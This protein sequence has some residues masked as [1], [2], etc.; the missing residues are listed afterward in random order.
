MRRKGSGHQRERVPPQH[1]PRPGAEGQAPFAVPGAPRPGDELGRV[2]GQR[3]PGDGD[4]REHRAGLA[5]P[6]HDHDEHPGDR[7]RERVERLG[8]RMRQARKE[9]E[10]QRDRVRQRARP[11]RRADGPPRALAEAGEH[12]AAECVRAEPVG[13]ARSLQ[14]RP[15]GDAAAA[16]EP[17]GDGDQQRRRG[18]GE[19]DQMAPPT[20]RDG[21]GDRD[22]GGVGGRAGEA[23]GPGPRGEPRGE[24]EGDEE[25]QARLEDREVLGVGGGQGGAAEPGDGEDGLDGD[26]RARDADG[27][28]RR[29]RGERR[30]GAAQEGA[31][32][33]GARVPGGAP[34]PHPVL[35]GDLADGVAA[36]AGGDAAAGQA[37]GERGQDQVRGPVE[38]VRG[39]EAEPGGEDGDAEGR[40]EEVGQGGE[41][42]DGDAAGSDGPSRGGAAQGGRARGGGD[43]G[44]D[45][46][47]RAHDGEGG[48]EG[49][50]DGVG[51]GFAAGP[52]GAE[53]A[54]GESGEPV[55]EDRERPGV[56]AEFGADGGEGGVGGLAPGVAG[57]QD[58][59][60]RVAVGD[61]GQQP[62]GGEDGEEDR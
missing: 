2:G 26:G 52:G 13:P 21:R 60:G 32:D 25:H 44:G 39:Q 47:G 24:A 30:G 31:G 41:G 55:A 23:A 36:E 1:P 7:H 50:E 27:H 17:V 51:D 4:D 15:G 16:D 61:P 54:A 33:P 6:Q 12:V 19:P 58:R 11:D 38:A 56:E 5:A 28:D 62:Y 48:A 57:A 18:A 9:A 42:G 37:H 3:R 45:E 59:Q 43:R 22:R 46:Q 49:R 10:R 14:A 20:A 8:Q 40:E 53:V 35:G 34:L 29:L